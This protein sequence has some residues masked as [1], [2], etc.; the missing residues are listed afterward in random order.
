M[1][2]MGVLGNWFKDFQELLLISL[3]LSGD[4]MVCLYKLLMYSS[5]LLELLMM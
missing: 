4:V 2:V 5:Y 1:R 3:S